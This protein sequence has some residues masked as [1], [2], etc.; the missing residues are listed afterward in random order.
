M[1]VSNA[2]CNSSSAKKAD[3]IAIICSLA[4]VAPQTRVSFHCRGARPTRYVCALYRARGETP[5]PL[6]ANQSNSFSES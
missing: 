4:S 6:T 3:L 2:L 5:R 1:M